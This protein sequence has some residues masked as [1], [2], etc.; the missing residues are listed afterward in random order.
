MWTTVT[1]LHPPQTVWT[2]QQRVISCG[3][4]EVGGGGAGGHQGASA[5]LTEWQVSVMSLCT[6]QRKVYRTVQDDRL[7]VFFPPTFYG[8]G[9]VTDDSRGCWDTAG[10]V[11]AAFTPTPLMRQDIRSPTSSLVLKSV[12]Q[13][14][15]GWPP[16]PQTLTQIRFS[17]CLSRHTTA[18]LFSSFFLYYF[19]YLLPFSYFL[20]ALVFPFFLLFVPSF[21]FPQCFV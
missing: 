12:M 20:S 5:G 21:L 14:C 13:M 2:R 10:H 8:L 6:N 17:C 16:N 1:N 7:S 4:E 9:R 3:G 18:F 11:T 15:S 19:L